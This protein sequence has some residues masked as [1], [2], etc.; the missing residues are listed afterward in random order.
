MKK[1]LTL[2][3][4]LATCA[5]TAAFADGHS[6]KEVVVPAGLCPETKSFVANWARDIEIF[7]AMAVPTSAGGNCGEEGPRV[8][9]GI[10]KKAPSA[11]EAQAA[12]LERCNESR[13]DLGRCVVIATVRPKS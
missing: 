5:T 9:A 2:T 10:S 12:A 11:R 7:G 3:A 4:A 8:T 1:I 6:G 13:G